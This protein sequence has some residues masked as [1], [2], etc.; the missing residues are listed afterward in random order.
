MCGIVGIVA[1]SY[2]N[3]EIYDA[4]TFLQHRGQDAAGIVT[5]HDGRFFLR[6]DN[7]LVRDVFRTRHMRRLVGNM[8]IGHVRYP[9][10]G[11]ASAAEAQPFYVN[12]PYGIALAH[13][14][15]LTNTV[16]LSKSIFK[17]DLR[18]INTN[19][20]SEVLLNVF[21]H[22][23]QRLGQLVPSEEDIFYAVRQLHRRC[24]GGYAVIAMITGIGIMG[25][26]DPFGIRPLCYG[27]R[28]SA[29]GTEYMVASESVALDSAGYTMVRD[30]A[31]GECI[32]IT[33]AGE[34]FT[35]Q[36]AETPVLSPC[37]FEYVY[38]ARPDSVMDGISVYKAR[39]KMGEYLADQILRDWPDHDIDVVIPIPDTSRTSAVELANKLGVKL[40]EGYI[41]NRYIGRT[42]IMPGQTQRQKSVRQKLNPI[43][44]E[45]RGK[46]VLLVDDSI[47]RG[48]TSTLI[49]EMAR[50]MGAKKV[51]FASA[52]PA[53]RFPNVYGIDMPSVDELV[54]HGRTDAE[55]GDMIGADRMIY[56]DLEDLIRSTQGGGSDIASF[57]CSVFD[58]NY[59]TGDVDDVYL[60]GLEALR[61]DDTMKTINVID[62]DVSLATNMQ[63]KL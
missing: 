3:Q 44:L 6:K 34:V 38:L 60:A 5:C 63:S 62:D 19:S 46:N 59:V 13:N 16:E 37:L 25:M 9:T 23:L 33:E 52:A 43:E 24:L 26:R 36:C 49:I 31:P 40:R 12:S 8:G 42:F 45:F 27:K 61:N 58:G 15:N 18:H 32:Y 2:V 55:V 29:Q 17:S 51:Y 7:G 20:D 47:V 41:K 53:V 56:Q 4:L 14:G 30:L 22:E 1:K 57:D 35:R 28:E 50:E 48:T 10:A 39:L 54:A 11:S 21:A